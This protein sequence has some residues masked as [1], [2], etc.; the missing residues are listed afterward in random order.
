MDVIVQWTYVNFPEAQPSQQQQHQP[1]FGIPLSQCVEASA[2]KKSTASDVPS[3][4]DLMHPV[5]V[6]GVGHGRS[7]SRT[8]MSS[9]AEGRIGMVQASESFGV[10]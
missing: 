10:M 9:L 7:D 6:S 1:V 2:R 3:A 4:E 8:S 5:G